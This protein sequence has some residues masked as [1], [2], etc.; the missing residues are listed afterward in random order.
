MPSRHRRYHRGTST[1]VLASQDE[2][3]LGEDLV[4]T[5]DHAAAVLHTSSQQRKE[6]TRRLHRNSLKR[7]M[8]WIK[9]NYPSYYE[10]GVRDLTEEEMADRS[11]AYH[12]NKQDF[13]YKGMNPKIIMGY[14]GANKVKKTNALG[15]KIIYSE[16]WAR[17][18]HDAILFGAEMAEE[19]LPEGYKQKLVSF[20]ASYK[21]ETAAAKERGEIDE[22]EADPISYALYRRILTWSLDAGNVFCWVWGTLQ[23]NLMS[24]SINVDPLGFGNISLGADSV[25][26][27]YDRTK[28]DQEGEH[29]NVKQLFA[30]PFDPTVNVFL[31][32]G[33]WC[34]LRQEQLGKSEKLFLQA[35]TNK[36]T[37]SSRYCE[38]LS[39]LFK[40]N[41]EELATHIRVAHASVHGQRKGSASHAAGGTTAPPNF[42]SIAQRA[43]WS[44]GKVLD[45]YIHY[46][47]HGDSYLGRI[48]CG[49]DPKK[50][51]FETLCP[52]WTMENPMGDPDVEM[53]YEV[54]FGQIG[55][56]W[57]PE[58]TSD[59]K[60]V[61]I[62]CLASMVYHHNWMSKFISK[63]PSHPFSTLS[64]FQ[65]PELVQ[66]L[67][68]KVTTEVTPSMPLA[69]G[70]PP[71]IEHQK[72]LVKLLDCVEELKGL[73]EKQEETFQ[74]GIEQAYEKYARNNGV[75]TRETVKDMMGDLYEGHVKG[76]LD[77]VKGQFDRIQ[78][79][80]RDLNK[81][82]AEQRGRHA[83]LRQEGYEDEGGGTGGESAQGNTRRVVFTPFFYSGR[84]FDVPQDFSF[85]K[86]VT[87][88]TGWDL[89][90]RGM[91]S[92][93]D[94]DG[95]DHPVK[96]FR[97]LKAKML[98]AKIRSQLTAGWAPIY[99]MMEE[100][101]DDIPRD[102]SQVSAA[103][104]ERLFAE[105]TEHVKKRASFIWGRRSSS[106]WAPSY[107]SKNVSRAMIKKLGKDSDIAALPEETYRNKNKGEGLKRRRVVAEDGGGN[108]VRRRTNG[109]TQSTNAPAGGGGISEA[110]ARGEQ[111]RQAASVA[112]GGG[113]TAAGGGGFAEAFAHVPLVGDAD[114]T[115]AQLRRQNE[116]RDEA[117][118]DIREYRARMGTAQHRRNNL[119]DSDGNRLFHTGT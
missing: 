99:R 96:P 4:L 5:E 81:T 37:G 115:P 40:D 91:P 51:E 105:G 23:W 89:W 13:V 27:K 54:S 18:H 61:L 79:Q 21:K 41:V 29:C 92:Y 19:P 72:T 1:Q 109:P 42:T 45:T 85:P 58:S 26:I 17:K 68:S 64:L 74:R 46:D 10:V 112:G 73:M 78:D 82:V 50:T 32:L 118:R 52:H 101:I 57:D 83:G 8:E 95:K 107:W 103:Q 98:P 36:G 88:R 69:T 28:T 113:T 3:L 38:Q 102:T 62:R 94:M 2:S 33:V 31:A 49:L 66:Q 44:M 11:K 110:F 76:Q 14:I 116:V 104:A 47:A 12:N 56:D 93:R 80:L 9:V 53:L 114:L 63:N 60:G 7:M 24:R 65:Y 16:S 97:Q 43:E 30:N 111:Q 86:D 90:L 39:K 48:L 87:R 59:P 34:S 6:Q 67:S 20:I 25:N 77:T 55:S 119:Q 71:H 84:M 22:K 35:G 70:I 75:V 15:A 106:G 100:G 108:R 117:M